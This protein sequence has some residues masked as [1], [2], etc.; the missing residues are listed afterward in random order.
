MLPRMQYRLALDLGTTSIGWALLRLSSTLEPK[1]IIKMG[2]RIFPEGRN[3][4]DGTSLAVTR[5]EARQARRRRD[6]LLKR[7]ARMVE[8]L[9]ELGFW[10]E[11]MSERKLLATLDPYFLRKKALDEQL[12]PQEFGRAIFHLNQRRGFKSN[13]KTDAGDNESSL[14]KSTIARMKLRLEDENCRT[15]GEWLA[16]RHEKKLSVRA[17]LR[18]RTVKDKAY[19]FYA[20]RALVENEFDQLWQA[21]R[22]YHPLLF[23]EKAKAQLKDILLYQRPLKPVNPG[24]CTLL[25]DLKRAP[26]ALPSSQRIRIYQEVNNLRIIARDLTLIPLTLEQRDT[27][28]EMLEKSRD[29]KFSRMVKALK[30][31]G[32]TT[33]NLQDIKRDRLKGNLTSAILGG[34]KCFGKDW[35]NFDHDVQE[36]IVHQLLEEPSETALVD[37][38]CHDTGV[39]KESAL[40]IASIS[41]P[42]GY[43]SLSTEAIDLILPELQ[44]DVCT[45]DHAVA[46]AGLGSH[47]ALSH[48]EKTGELLDQLPYY[49]EALKRHVGFGTNNPEDMVEIQYGKIANP[50][51]HIGLNEIRKVI[52]AIIKRY[53]PPTQVVLEV[54]RDLK[55]GRQRKLEILKEQKKNQTRNELLLKEACRALEVNPDSLH[56]SQRREL[57]HKMQL[58]VELNPKDAADRRCPFSGEQISISRLLSDQ[59]EIEHILPY[60][61]TLDDSLTNKTLAIRQA[62]RDKGNRTPWEAFGQVSQKGYDYDAIVQRASHMKQAKRK[63]FAPDG[64]EQWLKD[65][66]DFLARALADTSYISRLAREYVTLICPKDSVWVIPGQLTA[67]LRGKLGLNDILSLKGVKNRDDHRHHAIDAAVIG[68]TDRGMLQ[69]VARANARAYRNGS[70]RL[71][72]KMPAPWPTYR[73]HVARATKVI[74][75]SFKPDHGYQ[76]AMH[77]ETA[78]GIM[79]DGKARRRVQKDDQ[80]FRTVEYA[81]KKLVEISSTKDPF[82]HGQNEDGTPAA[83]KGYV[84][85][86]N[87]CIEIW[88]D[89]KGKWKGDVISTFQAYQVIRELGEEQG[90]KRLRSKS[91][92]QCGKP[93]T[94]RL[95]IND[96]LKM[97][98]DEKTAVFRVCQ[99]KANTQLVLADS[100]ASNVDSRNRDKT[101]PF[102]YVTKTAGALKATGAK[103]V[104][105]NPLGI[106]SIRSQRS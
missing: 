103:H 26:Q 37:W 89:E 77:E 95:M 29:V 42:A 102:S 92:T 14:M 78:W 55:L 8:A 51:V 96:L 54:A 85:G 35:H 46:A 101:D 82:R 20:D 65:D 99:I 73:E 48:Q 39:S 80:L 53:G 11:D 45:F 68:I 5:R 6:R 38:L 52:N 59:I 87:Y 49:G 31:P 94:M 57:L 66:K 2:V 10:P 63:R 28:V 79:G 104:T 71:I 86:S 83:Y 4:K 7:K 70:D 30:L 21:Q 88:E 22:Q 27:L 24:R 9:V 40:R 15:L 62:N 90:W 1:A 12:L 81:Q 43:G 105:V 34:A 13:R 50:T 93:L 100:T 18:G 61:R 16:N 56:R 67:K 106:I 32:T 58:W 47:S 84:G 75:V 23:T 74:N 76:G 91:K 44:R 97:T 41:L 72:E 3:P 69:K 60:S 33:F 19:D 98:V 25:S 36:K 64:Y 17:R